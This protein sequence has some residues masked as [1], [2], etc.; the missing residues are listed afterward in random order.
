MTLIH[1]TCV[2]IDGHGVL[3]RGPSGSGKS[4]LALRLI[5]A[6]A[7]LVGDDYCSYRTE[8]GWDGDIL[9][10]TSRP[11][12]AGILE[13]RG[14]GL[15][16]VGHVRE[17]PVRLLFDLYPGQV[18]DRMPARETVD[19]HG[20]AVPRLRLDPFQASATAKVRLA[21]RVITGDVVL[22]S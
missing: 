20:V 10:A 22:V 3:L 13:V 4:D 15:V 11:E 19:L 2:S 1:A 18:P 8:S 14:L 7:V 21:V 5:E 17:A 9:I 12:M 16:R 6:G